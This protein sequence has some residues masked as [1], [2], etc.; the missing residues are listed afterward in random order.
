MNEPVKTDSNPRIG[1]FGW[2]V[3]APGCDSVDTFREKLYAGGSWL[4]KFE[5][6]GPSNFLV[7]DPDFDFE[8][9]HS[10]MMTVSPPIVSVNFKARWVTL[11]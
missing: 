8:K 7:G 2:G 3:I 10:W 11:P 4:E 6:F 1:I 9:Y 5:D